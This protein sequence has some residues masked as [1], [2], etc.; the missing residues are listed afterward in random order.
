MYV[1]VKVDLSW[2]K[3][4]WCWCL[5]ASNFKTRQR[6]KLLWVDNWENGAVAVN[7]SGLSWELFQVMS[8]LIWFWSSQLNVL[9]NHI[10]FDI[11][12]SHL[13]KR[14][15][16]W[17]YKTYSYEEIEYELFLNIWPTAHKEGGPAMEHVLPICFD[18]FCSQ[19]LGHLI[20]IGTL[21]IFLEVWRSRIFEK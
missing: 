5:C 1:Y 12:Y 2:S 11:T 7:Y 16:F 14:M 6:K 3:A 17:Y 10:P 15:K 9:K 8:Q 18:S 13:P 21:V 4:D 19:C 20:A